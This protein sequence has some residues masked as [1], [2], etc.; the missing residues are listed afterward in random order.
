[1]ATRSGESLQTD[2]IARPSK[3]P[4]GYTPDTLSLV[5]ATSRTILQPRRTFSLF[6][7]QNY[8]V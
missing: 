4:G 5:W 8:T 6:V 7:Y 1:M 3:L 2:R